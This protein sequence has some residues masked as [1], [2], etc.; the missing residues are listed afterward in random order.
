MDTQY[1]FFWTQNLCVMTS[2]IYGENH[3][4]VN[5]QGIDNSYQSEIISGGNT[6]G[7]LCSFHSGKDKG[8]TLSS[9]F[10][11]NIYGIYGFNDIA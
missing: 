3:C 11:R 2:D 6:W 5:G 4:V 7:I 8:M 10:Q 9:V 1:I